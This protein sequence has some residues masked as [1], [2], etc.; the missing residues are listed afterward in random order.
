MNF[1]SSNVGGKVQCSFDVNF[2]IDIGIT[3]ISAA[4][5]QFG[6]A[7]TAAGGFIINNVA[8]PLIGLPQV[9]VP[10]LTGIITGNLIVVY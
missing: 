7:I 2:D 10:S 6:T 8:I 5:V 9:V 1:C 3:A 4:T